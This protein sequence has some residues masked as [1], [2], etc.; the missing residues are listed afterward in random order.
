MNKN[1]YLKYLKLNFVQMGM[2][3]FISTKILISALVL[4]LTTILQG[5]NL[6]LNPGFEDFV[7]CPESPTPFDES[8]KL[9]LYWAYPTLATPDYFNRCSKGEVGV[10]DNFAGN[11]EPH[12]GNGYVGS[13]LSGS[14]E[15]Y[16]EYIEGQ[17]TTTLEAGKRYCVSYWYKLASYSKFSVDQLS[18]YLSDIPTRTRS[19]NALGFSPQLNNLSGLFLDNIDDW[20]QMCQ[21]YTAKG[22]EKFFIIG[23]FKDYDNTN[24]VVTDKNVTNK[25]DKAY[26]YYFFD[27][28][29]IRPL[30]NCNDCPC[31]P[32]NM[33]VVIM[34]SSYTGG[35][36]PYTGKLKKKKDDGKI[37]LSIIGGTAPYSVTWSNNQKGFSLTN[38]PSGKYTY[39]VKDYYNCTSKGTVT[40]TAPNVEMESNEDETFVLEEGSSIVLENI[41]FDYNKTTLLSASFPE[42]DKVVA[43]I[44][45]NNIHVVE[46]S[47]HTDSDGSDQYNQKLSE[48]RAKSVVVYL[49]EKGIGNER[50]IAKGYGESKP[51]DTNST[52]NGKARNRRVE[53][54]IVKR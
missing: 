43:F 18:L 2:I 40:F 35:L 6:V 37:S 12:S 17:L 27:D 15:N 24:Y 44:N 48:G 39:S 9:T 23:N 46:I 28:V 31:V 49:A 45:D 21:V 8:H 25:R 53:F 38:L 11:S 26:A 3:N 47:G 1:A 20:Q 52:E 30:D 4:F 50:L 42:L 34:D 5:Q 33:E 10:P 22:G 29:I 19:K 14:E 7:V 41:F 32:Q 51:I 36:N 54:K 16:R 13:I